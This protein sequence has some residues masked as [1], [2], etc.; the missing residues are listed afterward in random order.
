MAIPQ[1]HLN[2]VQLITGFAQT[3]QA[4]DD[5]GL[6]A[7]LAPDAQLP[8]DLPDANTAVNEVDGI[9]TTSLTLLSATPDRQIYSGTFGPYLIR[10]NPSSWDTGSNTRWF[11]L[12]RRPPAG[13]SASFPKRLF[14]SNSLSQQTN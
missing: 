14:R 12:S 11:A 9:S 10:T 6:E 3:L 1:D 2:T 13:A 5:I 4:H 8:P 7:L